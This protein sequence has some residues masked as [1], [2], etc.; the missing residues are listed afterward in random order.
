MQPITLTMV[1]AQTIPL[2]S[3]EQRSERMLQD[4]DTHDRIAHS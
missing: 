3:K 1:S 4:V 2:L